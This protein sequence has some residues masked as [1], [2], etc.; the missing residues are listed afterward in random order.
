MLEQFIAEPSKGPGRAVE[1]RCQS[2][3]ERAIGDPYG[4]ERSRSGGPS[5]DHRMPCRAQ[6]HLAR[7]DEREG[8]VKRPSIRW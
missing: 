4:I 3:L 1:S 7:K 2:G 5:R 8:G 6:V